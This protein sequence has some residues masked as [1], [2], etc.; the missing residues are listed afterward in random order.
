MGL[1]LLGDSRGKLGTFS[2]LAAERL[3]PDDRQ[4]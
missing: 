3:L 2:D 4:F 1:L